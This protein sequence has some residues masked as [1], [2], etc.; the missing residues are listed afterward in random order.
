MLKIIY[1]II[2]NVTCQIHIV[3]SNSNKIIVNYE[4]LVALINLFLFIISYNSKAFCK[5]SIF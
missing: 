2:Q 4:F 3:I 5:L 1:C